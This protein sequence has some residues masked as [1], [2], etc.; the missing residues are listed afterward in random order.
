MAACASFFFKRSGARGLVVRTTCGALQLRTL[1]Q[2]FVL[3][4]ALNNQFRTGTNS[5][6]PTV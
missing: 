2:D 3:R 6:N 5:G 1:S 4:L